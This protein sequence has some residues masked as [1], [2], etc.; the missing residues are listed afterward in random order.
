[1]IHF[2]ETHDDLVFQVRI[3]VYP[4][5]SFC[6]S[7]ETFSEEYFGVW[8]WFVP[9][10]LVDFFVQK[11]SWGN[12]W[13]NKSSMKKIKWSFLFTRQAVFGAD[14]YV[15][16]LIGEQSNCLLAITEFIGFFVAED[17]TGENWSGAGVGTEFLLE[18]FNV[19]F[20]TRDDDHFRFFGWRNIWER[21]NKINKRNFFRCT[22]PTCWVLSYDR[23]ADAWSLSSIDHRW[24]VGWRWCHGF[25]LPLVFSGRG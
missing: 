20:R 21:K 22:Y 10:D 1:M 8:R 17:Q 12:I 3:A 7:E 5:D 6:F 4:D 14:E 24:Q 11:V 15:S 16:T 25:S 18:R 23:R 9:D 13:K 2:G 19:L